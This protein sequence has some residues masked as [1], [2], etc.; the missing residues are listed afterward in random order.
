MDL[1][2]IHNENQ[3]EIQTDSNSD[4]ALALKLEQKARDLAFRRL[5]AR[6]STAREMRS[7]L[8]RKGVVPSLIEKVVADLVNSDLINEER[9]LRA[10]IRST[11]S[12][13]KGPHQLLAALKRKGIEVSLSTLNSVLHEELGDW[14]EV[15]AARRLVERRYRMYPGVPTDPAVRR[16]AFQTLLRRGFSSTVARKVIASLSSGDEIYDGLNSDN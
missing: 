9:Y 15:E 8:G 11:A 12:M 14:D 1:N 13:K 6:E 3:D 10:Y 5:S 2:E 7:Y 16:R 4:F